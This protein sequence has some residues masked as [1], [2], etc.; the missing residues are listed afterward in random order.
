MIANRNM[1]KSLTLLL[2][3]IGINSYAQ[4]AK[5]ELNLQ[6]DST[7]NLNLNA[8]FDVDQIGNG[9]HH[10]AKSTITG[11]ITH[12]VIAIIDTLYQL[13]VR[14]K[15]LGM[16]VDGAGTVIEFN[17][18]SKTGNIMSSL[19]GSIID[20]PFLIEMSKTGRIVSVKNIDS[21][22]INMASEFPDI[23]EEQKNQMIAQMKQSFGEKSIRSNFQDAFV[24][25]PKSPLA[26]KGTW[27]T[28]NIMEASPISI[29]IKTTY[30]LNAITDKFY[31]VT[32]LAT[33]SPDKTGTFRKSGDYY[34]R[35][36]N[37]N[38]KYTAKIKIDKVTGWVI[39]SYVTKNIDATSEMK[40]SATGPVLLS[41]PVNFSVKMTNTN[42]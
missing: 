28:T 30:T 32:G 17:S 31:E 18:D 10:T 36:L 37:A 1:K 27:V 15:Q 4:T 23:S 41:A 2:L 34:I 5:L 26:L 11:R 8:N 3:F 33:V 7:Y 24:I 9:V 19:L 16:R 40:K 20:K 42:Q 35:F 25:F 6:K 39:D 38:G 22:F 13:E 21:L 12:K 29:K 14:Y